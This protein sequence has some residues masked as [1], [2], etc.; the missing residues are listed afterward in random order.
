MPLGERQGDGGAVGAVALPAWA[1]GSAHEFARL[2]RAAL[3]SE[4]VS[5][6]LPAWIDLVFGPAQQGEAAVRACNVFHYLTYEVLCTTAAL[7]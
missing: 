7:R 1:R 3:E 2:H 5:A 6:H 4:H